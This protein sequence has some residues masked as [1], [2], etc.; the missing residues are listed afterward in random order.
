MDIPHRIVFGGG[1]R[2]FSVRNALMSIDEK[3]CLVAVHDGVRPLVSAEVFEKCFS[4]AEVRSNAVTCVGSVDSVRLMSVGGNNESVDRD[5]VKLIQ[6]PQCFKL[7][8]LKKAY[9]QHY[10][11][12]FTDDASL[13]ENLGRKIY[14]CEGSRENIKIT[15]PFDLKLAECLL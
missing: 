11:K 14:L 3:E 7:S 4:L 12:K 15:T 5:R 9:S 8:L 2:F 6:T 13:V 1:E 10:D